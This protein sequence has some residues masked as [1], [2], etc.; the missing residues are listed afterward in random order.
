MTRVISTDDIRANNEF[1]VVE[2]NAVLPNRVDVAFNPGYNPI[3]GLIT[4]HYF[5]WESGV[6]ELSIQRG[7]SNT[8]SI[9]G[10]KQ[11][12]RSASDLFQKQ[13]QILVRFPINLRDVAISDEGKVI[14]E[15]RDSWMIW[16]PYVNDFDL[17]IVAAEDSP[18]NIEWR[19][20]IVNSRDSVIQRELTMQM[21]KL[22]LLEQTDARYK[23]PFARVA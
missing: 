16:T 4:Y 11:Y 13:N 12:L 2:N 5:T 8:Q 3:G 18:D 9:F 1:A 19:Y 23:L 17:L 22:N 21:F 7:D 15:N 6:E 14:L 10:W 20:E